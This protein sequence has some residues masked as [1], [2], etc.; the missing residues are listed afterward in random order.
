MSQTKK[1]LETKDNILASAKKLFYIHGLKNVSTNMICKEANVKLGTLTYYFNKKDDLLS[2]FYNDYMSRINQFVKDSTDN[3]DPAKAH[4]YMILL[5][6]FNI[7]R[8]CNVVR[9][10][11]EV[12]ENTSMY[13]ILYNQRETIA[14]FAVHSSLAQN[15]DMF[16]IL[17][18]ADN[19][20][21][22]EMNLASA[23]SKQTK[24]LTEVKELVTKIYTVTAQLFSYDVNLLYEHIDE[25][26]EFL[27]Q[28][29]HQ[30]I[31]LLL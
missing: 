10:H 14:P 24:D 11:E 21:R 9:F 2:Y 7:Y 31:H 13:N 25:G 12:L 5:Y 18:L 6:Y 20:V 23:K 4:I 8:D 3:L 22:R 28:H 29:V 19:A 16:E 30:F 15:D 17:I 1:G 27:L 26:Y